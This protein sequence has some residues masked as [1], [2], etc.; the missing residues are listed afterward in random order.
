ML[1]KVGRTS[2]RTLGLSMPVP[3]RGERPDVFGTGGYQLVHGLLCE[4]STVG[5][6]PQVC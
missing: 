1:T 5:L 4:G 6:G 2:S 3:H